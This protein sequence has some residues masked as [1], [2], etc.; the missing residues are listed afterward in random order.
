MRFTRT[1]TAAL[2][3]VLTGS[4]AMAYLPTLTDAQLQEAY[5]QAQ[6]LA[7]TTDSG[8]PVRPYTLYAVEDTLKLEAKNGAVDAVVIATPFERTRYQTFLHKIGDDP[9]TAQQ[10]REQADL[11]DHQVAFIVFAHGLRLDDQTFQKNISRPRLTLGGRTLQPTAT[12]LSDVSLSQYPR[13]VGELGLR[14]IGTVTYR[15]VVPDSLN[16]AKGTLSFTD[17]SGKA[18]SMAVDLTKYR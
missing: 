12:A 11:P 9:I 1:H 2:L 4:Q 15:Y 17:S 6:R 14:Y 3:A 8:Y 7:Q 5:A 18:Y 13:T 10:A 16:A